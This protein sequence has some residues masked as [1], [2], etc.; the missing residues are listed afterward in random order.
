MENTSLPSEEWNNVTT[1]STEDK[2]HVNN[3]VF[4]PLNIF[5][6]SVGVFGNLFVIVIFILFIKI[7]GKVMLQQMIRLC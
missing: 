2:P 7:A 6:G 5:I 4:A 3:D 1:S